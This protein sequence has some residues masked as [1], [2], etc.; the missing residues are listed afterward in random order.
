MNYLMSTSDSYFFGEK[1]VKT[2]VLV[3]SYVLFVVY[4]VKIIIKAI[5]STMKTLNIM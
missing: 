5:S 3:N 4:L 1:N 2:L